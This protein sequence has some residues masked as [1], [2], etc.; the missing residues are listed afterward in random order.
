MQSNNTSMHVSHVSLMSQLSIF[1]FD[2]ESKYY[3]CTINNVILRSRLKK[4]LEKN[5]GTG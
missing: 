3:F 4:M 1:C 2:S 5:C